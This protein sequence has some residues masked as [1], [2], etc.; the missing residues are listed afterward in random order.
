MPLNKLENFIRNTEGR[1]LY[2]NPNDLD[3]TDSIDNQGNSLT[4]PFKTIQRALLESA[5]FSYLR[6]DNNDIVEKTTILLFPG[7]HLIDNRP[8][9][10]IKSVGGVATA[11]APSG[12][13]TVAQNEL[14]L[15]LTSNFDLTQSENI[16]YKFNSVYGGV[17]VPRGTSIVGL[18]LRKTKIR[19]KYVPNPTDDLLAKSAI[20]RITGAC[21]FW[22]F[23]IFD[24]DE[25]TLVYTDAADFSSNN[26]SK[27]TFS[28][29]KLT[30]FEY[31]DG[32]NLPSG[33]SLTDL[34]MYYSKL[35]NAFNLASGRDID[36]KYP[37][38][39]LGFA[40]Q[41]PE[42]EIVGA[43]ASDP[44]NVSTIISG[45][46]ATPGSIVTVTT[47]VA[48]GLTAGTPIKIRGVNVDDYNISTKVQTVT[49][50]TEFTYVLPF[51]RDNLPAGSA[52]GLSGSSA[53]VTIETDTV[54]GASP[55]IFNISLRSVWGMNGMHAD[56]SKAAGF[57]SMV[58]AQF[59]AVSLQKDDRA[60][61]KYNES[62]RVYDAISYTKVTG[63]AL[64]S[65]SSSTNVATV[66]HLDSGAIYRHGWQPVHIKVSN[67]SFIQVVSVFAIGF[68][69]H[70][71]VESGGDASITNSN[72]NFGQ[73][74]LSAD[75]FKKEAFDKD[76]KAFITSIIT[77][78]AV[79]SEEQNIDWIS[80]DV[81]KINQ[82]GLS[83]HLY[84]FG[85]N[86]PDIEPPVITQGYRVGARSNE[87]LYL[88]TPSG[89][90]TA[91]ILMLDNIIG[92]GTT[93]AVGT[94]SAEKLYGATSTGSNILTLGS[95]TIQTGEKI[96]V[97]SDAGDLPENL[98]EN[99]IYY[100][101]RHSSTEIK[102]AS[103]KTNAEA[104]TPLPIT[105]YGGTQ[106]KVV[107]RVS[108]KS[109]DEIGS[110]IQ[111]DSVNSGWY[112]H[113]NTNNDIYTTITSL[114]VAG[115]TERSAVSY[116]KRYE[117]NRSL[118]EKLYKM[119]I[120]VPKELT[121]GRDPNEG[122]IIQESSTTGARSD[123]DFSL[124]SITGGDYLFERNPR[125]ISTCT[126]NGVTSVVTVTSDIPHNLKVGDQIIV[127]NVT[128]TTN[129][130]GTINVGYNG[131]FLVASVVNDKTFTYGATD[132]FGTVH[133]P[134][135]FTNN[136]NVRSVSLPRFERNDLKGNFFVYRSEVVTPYI[137][138]VQDGVYHV[139][140]LNSSNSIPSEFTNLKY[141]QSLT[142]LYPQLDKDNLDENPAASV[143]FAYREPLGKTVTNDL[144]KSI[145]RE[146]VDK[147]F[148]Y[149]GLSPIVTG[150]TTSSSGITTVTFNREHQLNGVVTYNTLTAG[151]GHNPGTYYNVKLY[152]ENTLTTWDGATAKV[153]VSAGGSVTSLDIISGGSAY[154]T[155][156]TLYL[157]SNQI[158][159]SP[160]AAITIATSG[161]STSVGNS[162]QFTGLGTVTD[163]YYRV[164]DI[165][166]KNQIAVGQTSG[167]PT[168]I[169]G[170]YFVNIAPSINVNSAPSY[171]SA[172]G[173]STFVC[174]SPHGLVAGN[175]FRVLDSAHNNL[176]D[177]VV[178]E[179]ISPTSFTSKTRKSIP[180]S[181]KLLKHALSANEATSDSLGENLG[182]RGVSLYQNEIL[183]LGQTITNDTQF[184]VSVPNAGIATTRRFPLGSY[185]QI[186][187]EI[188][189]ITSSTLSGSG[190]D[191][192]QVIRGA[193]G[194]L[195]E[196]H[197]SGSMIRKI[198]PVPIELRR[199]SI[200]RASGHT[201]EYMGYGPGNYSTG[202][203]QVQ[204]RTLTEREDFLAQS[205]ESSCGTVV[206][207]GMN[208]DGDF[209]I[210]NTKYSAQSGEQVTFDIPIPTVTGQDPSRLSV[211][212]DEVI[213]KERIL[214]EGGNSGQILS[215]FDGPV[216]FNQE[217]K[218]NDDV[219]INGTVKVNNTVE[220][221]DTT[222][223]T[224]CT[225][226][227]LIVAGGVG[228]AKT[229]NVC[230]N[231]TVGGTTQSIDTT[232][233]ALV[234]SGGVGIAKTV[235]I[236][237][238]AT[239]GGTT[240]S[241]SK[242]TGA[243]IVDGG[244]GIEKNANIGGDVTI[245]GTTQSININSGALIVD[246]GVGIEKN[247]FVGGTL[248]VAG[249]ATIS[250]N[251]TAEG[252]IR[253]GDNDHLYL[254][255]G[256]D[257]DLYHNGAN[258]F[259]D[260]TGAG[261]LFI[262]GTSVFIQNYDTGESMIDATG[263]GAI[264]LYHD[265]SLKINTRTDG[266]RVT[267]E[268]S[269]TGDV[270]AFVS[271]ERLKTNIQP[272]ENALDKVLQLSG[273]TY[274]FN[275]T[276]GSLGFN[277]EETH[278][279][280]SAQQVQAVL[281]EAVKPAPVSGDYI[282]V[283]YEKIVPLLIEAIKELSAKVDALEK[284]I[285]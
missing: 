4:K 114:G 186:N 154:T 54:S 107:S 156:E 202:L 278:V 103:S 101:I 3:A 77:P 16:L 216:T 283:Q 51:V 279:G 171:D 264:N 226:G 84:L 34:D 15:T 119:R 110:P 240:Q 176:G 248:S 7:E 27:P 40:K 215:Q 38:Q 64:A 2:V 274:T 223:S 255:D 201:F 193:M 21:Y 129:T 136:T 67:D 208:S 112:I 260:D 207:T 276:A 68:N 122:F 281:P 209:F 111:W 175:R 17:V 92:S 174:G 144:R 125:F 158:G 262:R 167:D 140:L 105:I 284:K 268:F 160:S 88:E 137:Y 192:I 96:R 139:Y 275:E 182:T 165:P 239:I 197:T 206:Y 37:D 252:N 166:A 194:T 228:I 33:Y 155:G 9:Y 241:T 234:V 6:G 152:N 31:A 44:I 126:F 76:N 236:G 179:L 242:D 70:F 212:F 244:V 45:D 13:E 181:V 10:A 133:A 178:N 220:V 203:P 59:T 142:D 221:T 251:I 224:S 191:E 56:G 57:R 238:N 53:T 280:V 134:G 100:A 130:S 108:D 157:D 63:A 123:A 35:S 277:T 218:M 153:V 227:A 20:F 97:I 269:A 60:F 183:I 12:A 127:K 180:A 102:I 261:S 36:Q 199:P 58:V 116:F 219:Q 249:I 132:V 163:G 32:V 55:Y 23:S 66:Y 18:D 43:F 113:A 117:D 169:A 271:D 11:V 270:I 237:G 185:I 217:L 282:T 265:G 106:L 150:I 256:N 104:A 229:L 177:F 82:V 69:K 28:H 79:V 48:H 168:I 95:H 49:S 94:W 164:L 247:L 50:A 195:K 200:I 73:F 118:D 190:N 75:G 98:E 259:I 159:G 230:G 184:K 71:A 115:L 131:T 250:G 211:V 128:S 187:N 222:Q 189:R 124:A 253:F 62:N 80:F 87:T 65:G 42:W 25:N 41:R 273:F 172:T 235:N 246:G 78:R 231:A 93:I 83:S 149:F 61:V 90:K 19:P 91:S 198:K 204:N 267:G 1:I 285:G 266:A 173:I 30:C 151:T 26:Q 225:T 213:V 145:T 72:S 24:G 22:Q 143:T 170:Q 148:H 8:G 205:Q 214:V 188:M 99:V 162:V 81:N 210:G 138:N 243:L 254:G 74:S 161:I 14:S 257:L 141:S 29:H 39:N 121:N 233:G 52:G 272:L 85:F 46:G 89:T 147:F 146:T 86:N 120:V 135:A 232:S 47:T 263:N 245:L 196:N 258:S 109:A 5:R